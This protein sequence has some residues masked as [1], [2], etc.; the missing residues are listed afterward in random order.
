[1]RSPLIFCRLQDTPT[2][3]ATATATTVITNMPTLVEIDQ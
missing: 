2:P 3:T 1:M